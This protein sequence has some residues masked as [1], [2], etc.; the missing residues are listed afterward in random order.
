MLLPLQGEQTRSP[1][2]GRCP[3]LCAFGLSARPLRSQT[4]STFSPSIGTLWAFITIPFP[5]T[6]EGKSE[7]D[8]LRVCGKGELG[9]VLVVVFFLISPCART[10]P[11]DLNQFY[12]NIHKKHGKLFAHTRKS[13]YLCSVE[14]KKGV[15][16]P[17]KI[18]SST[19]F[20]KRLFRLVE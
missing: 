14:R 15:A 2:L 4:S 11:L 7:I 12:A 20:W 1:Y 9:V 18:P 19:V 3:R 16:T 17:G 6:G 8:N 5:I 10:H 13:S